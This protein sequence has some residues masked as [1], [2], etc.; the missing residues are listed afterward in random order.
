M[1]H[2]VYLFIIGAALKIGQ[3][4]SIQDETVISPELQQVFERVRQSADFMPKW[5]VEKVLT[6]ELGHDWRNKLATF[7]DRPFAAASIGNSI[8]PPFQLNNKVMEKR[9]LHDKKSCRAGTS[10][11]LAKWTRCGNKNSIPWRSYWYSERCRKFSRHNEGIRVYSLILILNFPGINSTY[12]SI[13]PF[14][15]GMYFQK[16]CSSII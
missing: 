4:L 1:L 3:I 16:E 5:Q 12:I 8:F 6:S 11:Y 7:Q 10:W 2:P 14:R 9:F 13:N 15:F